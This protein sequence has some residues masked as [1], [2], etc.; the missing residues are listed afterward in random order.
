M[1]ALVG[2]HV[3]TS[4]VVDSHPVAAIISIERAEIAPVCGQAVRPDIEGQDNSVVGHVERSPIRTEHDSVR[5]NV[6]LGNG[7]DGAGRVDVVG[8]THREIRAAFSIGNEIVEASERLAVLEAVGQE[9]A[10]RRQDADHGQLPATCAERFAGIR[11]RPLH[12]EEPPLGIQR[13][14]ARAV[15][16]RYVDELPVVDVQLADG[17]R[18]F[19]SEQDAAV[20]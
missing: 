13:D 7:G 19:L 10:F 12:R 2:G 6:F 14:R 15:R 20:G 8:A 11:T 5:A 16:I 1:N 4:G 17:V 9:F 18:L 3:K